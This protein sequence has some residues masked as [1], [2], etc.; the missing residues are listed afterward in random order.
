[1]KRILTMIV[2]LL[3]ISAADAQNR[4]E[5]NRDNRKPG[6]FHTDVPNHL[7]DIIIGRPTNHSV[8]LSILANEELSGYISYGLNPDKP[9]LKSSRIDFR[10]GIVQNIE[11]ENLQPNKRYHYCLLYKGAD[12]DK[13]LASEPYFFQT[14]RT[15]KSSF[16]FTVQADSHLD[17]NT[18]TDI[19]LKTLQNMAADSADFLVDL[20]D[21]WMT[22]KYRTGYKESLKQY[23]AQRFYFG[24]V[25]KSSS[26]FL[27]LG[28]HDGES[29]QRRNQGSEENM[30]NWATQTRTSYYPNPIPNSFYSG[31]GEQEVGIGFPEN[32]YSW[33]WGNALFVVLDPFR[34]T[35]DNNN[36][37]QRTLGLKQYNWLKSTLQ[38]SKATFK[39]VFIHNLV[40]GADLNGKGRG[41]AEAAKFYEWGGE[42]PDGSKAFAENRSGW[43]KPLHDLLVTN[44]VD[45]VFHGHDHFFAKQEL[46]GIVYQEVP[47]PGAMRYGNT[48]SAHEY[49]YNSGKLLNCPGYLRIRVEKTKAI[50]DLLQTSTD[51]QHTNKEVLFSY[52]LQ[53]K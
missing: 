20:G 23:I 35:T 10:K 51:A 26:L 50:V 33:Q 49:G 13:F 1:M 4:R 12:S 38:K 22:D 36:P 16:S 30:T 6:V 46:D 3:A 39:F 40:G 21:T 19:Y 15:E 9:D 11:L 48:N 41:G 45:V 53:A 25:C 28:N 17:E 2:A 47:Q 44:K 32:Y 14:Q 31:N 29:G 24:S 5:G 52:T 7:F 8:T 43:E 27:T 37:W 42:N 18:G 34:Y